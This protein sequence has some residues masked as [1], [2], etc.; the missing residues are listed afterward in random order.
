MP[1]N[2]DITEDELTVQDILDGANEAAYHTILEVWREIMRPAE[3]ERG[4]PITPQWA[5][6][7]CST[8]REINFKD[9]P[10]FKEAYFDRIDELRNILDNEIASDDECL[11][12]ITAAED[13]EYNSAHYLNVLIDWQK[14]FLYW[15]IAWDCTNQFAAVDL[16]AI[17]EVHRMMFSDTGI[18]SL[19]DQINFQ[20]TEADQEM[21]AE[22]LRSIQASA[23]GE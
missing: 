7:I 20:F 15:E 5:N 19:L 22:T 10:A 1:E 21:L 9:M 2:T 13:V 14:A 16:A 6:R 18:T 8:Y 3:S 4:K 12:Q 11:N 17:S 23:Q